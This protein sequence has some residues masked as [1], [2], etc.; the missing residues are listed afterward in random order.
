[1]NGKIY[2]GNSTL[3]MDCLYTYDFKSGKLYKGDSTFALDALLFF[4]GDLMNDAE[5]FAVLIALGNL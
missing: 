3:M 5:L 1:M 4:Q 2:K